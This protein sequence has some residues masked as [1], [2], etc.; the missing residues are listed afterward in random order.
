MVATITCEPGPEEEAVGSSVPKTDGVESLAVDSTSFVAE[1][2]VAITVNSDSEM[3]GPA[4]SEEDD[5]K[6]EDDDDNEDSE[7][8][9]ERVSA[10]AAT[11]T[12]EPETE[13]GS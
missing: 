1:L 7:S 5:S 8:A 2:L 11:V 4:S 10:V 6:E 3:E 12:C 13:A 9:I